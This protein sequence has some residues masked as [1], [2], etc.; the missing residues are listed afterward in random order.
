MHTFMFILNYS[1][2]NIKL[3]KTLRKMKKILKFLIFF[4]SY[5]LVIRKHASKISFSKN[6]IFK[7][8][9]NDFEKKKYQYKA[10]RR[11]HFYFYINYF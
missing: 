5:R 1:F 4:I 9:Q 8:K 10:T 2:L 6:Q 3:K 7:N 11:K